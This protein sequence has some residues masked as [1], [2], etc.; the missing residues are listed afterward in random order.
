MKVYGPV[1]LARKVKVPSAFCCRVVPKAGLTEV[2]E[3]ICV[4]PV[5]VS[6]ASTSRRVLSPRIALKLSP[7]ALTGLILVSRIPNC[8]L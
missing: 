4:P 6:L 8:G 3:K 5:G 7:T 2:V 1:E